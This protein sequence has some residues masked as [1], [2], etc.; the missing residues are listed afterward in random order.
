[1]KEGCFYFLKDEYF[2]IFND[3]YLM[4]NKERDE[5]GEHRRPCF[6][7][8]KEDG[9]SIFW[10]IPISSKVPKYKQIYEY[11]VS[12]FHVCDILVFGDVLGQDRAFLI[13]NMCPVTSRYV[14]ETYL[15]RGTGV[16][17]TIADD[18]KQEIIR[19]A[20]K[21]LRLQRNGRKLIFPDV[22][23]IEKRLKEEEKEKK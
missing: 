8:F 4:G 9:S 2:E 5:T 11:K 1:M 13:Q 15:E 12:K 21:V 17:V 20:T 19:K 10:L 7:A 6:L 16:P 3:P 22:L 18:L 23:L 14:Q